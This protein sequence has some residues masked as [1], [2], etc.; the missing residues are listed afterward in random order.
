MKCSGFLTLSVECIGLA[1]CIGRVFIRVEA[2]A[3]CSSTH[4]PHRR[5]WP[6]GEHLPHV[7]RRPLHRPV[8]FIGIL[9][10]SIS[11]RM[12]YIGL[13]KRSGSKMGII[14]L[15]AC[16]GLRNNRRASS[17]SW[18]Y[19]GLTKRSGP[20]MCVILVMGGIGPIKFIGV[21]KPSLSSH[22]NY[23]GLTKYSGSKMCIF[24]LTACIIV[25]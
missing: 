18:K 7:V 23:I 10:P 8:K 20:R 11:G 2:S 15:M 19:I 13:T 6:H 17:S 21:L 9:E 4:R 16:I 1:E 22:L 24:V 14:Y 5:G 3:S 12:E 25:P